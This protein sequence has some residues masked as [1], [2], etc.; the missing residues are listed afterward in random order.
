MPDRKLKELESVHRDREKELE[1]LF[2]RTQWI[3]E[4]ENGEKAARNKPEIYMPDGID[5][6]K[7]TNQLEI[8]VDWKKNVTKK[9]F[10]PLIGFTLFWNLI[11]MIIAISMISGG[12]FMGLIFLGAHATVGMSMLGKIL[13]ILFNETKIVVHNNELLIDHSPI[14]KTFH[15]SKRL[16]AS[17]IQQFYVRRS[18]SGRVNGVPSYQYD[19]YVCLKQGKDINLIK[20]LNH[21]SLLFVEQE[22]ERYLDIPDRKIGQEA[23][24]KPN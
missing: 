5:V 11:I 3:F 7:M 12:A 1:E 17:E 18:V 9:S 13:S 4:E 23:N 6:L 10:L 2:D 19:L 14:F 24:Y 8:K 15:K 22:L 20:G 16:K 21:E